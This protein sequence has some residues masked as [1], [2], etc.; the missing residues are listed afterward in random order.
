MR[1][2]KL[3]QYKDY[4]TRVVFEVMASYQVQVIFTNDLFKSATRLGSKP[5]EE[6]DAF[7]F[8]VKGERRSYI[9]LKL[10]APES[11]VAHECWHIVHQVMAYCGVVDMDSEIVAYHLGHLVEKVYDFKKA[12]R[13]GKAKK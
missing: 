13:A 2:P 4:E 3:T 1:K 11:V 6:A 10:N 9:F 8:N 7:C 12:I 5:S